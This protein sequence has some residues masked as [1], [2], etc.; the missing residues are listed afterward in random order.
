MEFSNRANQKSNDRFN[1]MFSSILRCIF[2]CILLCLSGIPMMATADIYMYI[3]KKG[4][5]HFSDEKKSSEYKLL[6]RSDTNKKPNSF[7]NWK[8]KSYTNISIPRDKTLQREYHSIILKAAEKNKLDPAFL[9]AIIT[10]ESAYQR[11]AVSSAGAQGLMQLMPETAK[12]F[13]VTDSFNPTQNIY[14]GAA[15]LRILLKEFKS[16]ELAAAAYNAGEGAVRRYK[17]QVPPYPETQK[18]VSKV[19]TFYQYYQHNL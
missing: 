8:A 5:K 12:R 3:D 15:Y 18:Y 14:A 1:T 7:K 9:H 19:L 4:N 2:S 16:R 6:L 10:A 17:R 13:S 11:N